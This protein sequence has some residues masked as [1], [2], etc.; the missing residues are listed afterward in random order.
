MKQVTCVL[1]CK[2]ELGE[3]P[4]WT[5]R[6]QSLYWTDIPA[7]QI[8]CYTP[9]T[10]KHQVYDVPE[11]VTTLAE[12]A[13]GGFILATDKGVV[14]W[15][16]A[17][18]LWQRFASPEADLPDNRMNDGKTDRQ[19]RFWAGSMY[20]NWAPDG[21]NR[22]IL[23]RRG[24]LYRFDPNGTFKRFESGISC[25]NTFCW[26][27]DDKTFYFADSFSNVISAYD[28]NAKTGEISNKRPLFDSSGDATLGVPDGSEIDAEGYLWNTRYGGGC[29]LRIAPDGR[30]VQRIDMPCRRITS[31]IFGGP[32]LKTLYIVTA[33]D[34][35]PPAEL[36]DWPL[37]GGLF[38][39]EPGVGG[40]PQVP[41]AG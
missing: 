13:R 41:F 10:K 35:A 4:I 24:N 16:P 20:N 17:T 27:P 28:F 22:P 12:R 37:A 36:A 38:A 40:L 19:G 3:G 8:H 18:K 15:D 31:C 6:D 30:V 1:D 25:S 29:V 5:E 21:A 26:S 34:G 9:K 23:P 11:M 39:I 7:R 14:L 32:G 33:R 2:H